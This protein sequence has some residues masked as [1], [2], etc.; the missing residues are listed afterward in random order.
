MRLTV[1]PLPSTVYWR[2]RLLVLAVVLLA[3]LLTAWACSPGDTADKHTADTARQHPTGG[4]AVPSNSG[5]V[6]A[7]PSSADPDPSAS[8]TPSTA[9]SGSWSPSVRPR[10]TGPAPSC[11]DQDLSVSTAT[12]HRHI[13]DGSYPT[14]YLTIGNT[15]EH[16]CTRDI[17]ADQQELR[18]MHGKTRIWSSDDCDPNHGKD[19][20]RFEAGDTVTF[21]L[22]WSGR[23]SSKGCTATR[24]V[25]PRGHYQLVGRVGSKTGKPTSF[26]LT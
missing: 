14:L 22:V 13:P 26:I 11:A 6:S 23:T 21:H 1:G 5:S 4:L 15:A 9:P 17:G 18:V 24:T 16:A 7:G 3:V 8:A 20:R 10:P 25:P 2:R 12:K 19:V